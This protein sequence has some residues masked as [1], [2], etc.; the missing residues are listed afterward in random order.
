M[1]SITFYYVNLS[2]PCR[3]V[4]WALKLLGLQAEARHLSTLDKEHLTESFLKLNPQHTLPTL[5]DGNFSVWHSQNILT[6]LVDKYKPGHTL[7]PKDV[8]TRSKINQFLFF[9]A[10]SLFSRL[11]FFVEPVFYA[12]AKSI[13]EGRKA[14]LAN[15]VQLLEDTIEK[16]AKFLVGNNLTIADLSVASSVTASYSLLETKKGTY[17]KIDAWL[18]N[19]SQALPEWDAFEKGGYGLGPLFRNRVVENA[20]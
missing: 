5:V 14:G 18:A 9:E 19:L 7:F 8:E 4:E 13:D 12:G 20:K 10:G 17:P 11:R 1:S 3:A 6:Y 15:A 2:P 16:G